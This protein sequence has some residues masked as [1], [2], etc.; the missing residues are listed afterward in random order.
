[1]LVD[2]DPTTGIEATGD[3]VA[4]WKRG[5]LVPREKDDGID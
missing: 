5:I 1:M 3:I 4:V 2:G